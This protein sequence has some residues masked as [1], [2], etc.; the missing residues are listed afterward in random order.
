MKDSLVDQAAYKSLS[1]FQLM[2][3]LHCTEVANSAK[4]KE[5]KGKQAVL[6]YVLN[7][8]PN[9]PEGHNKKEARKDSS[10]RKDV[11]MITWVERK[12]EQLRKDA[13][14]G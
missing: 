13:R 14:T 5:L 11:V 3:F 10:G 2:A 1:L 9:L 8:H 12:Q 7:L 4:H 6:H